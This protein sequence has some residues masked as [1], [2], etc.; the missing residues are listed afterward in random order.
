[1]GGDC[2]MKL[3]GF[4]LI[5]NTKDIDDKDN[6]I[7]T[8]NIPDLEI[9]IDISVEAVNEYAKTILG[10]YP[11]NNIEF[12]TA[13]QSKILEESKTLMSAFKE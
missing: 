1:M 6:K 7:E 11:K 4:K 10:R 2:K 8:S 9:E 12:S 13:L 3:S 5:E